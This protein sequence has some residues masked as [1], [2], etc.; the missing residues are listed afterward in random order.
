MLE[1]NII[2]KV[3]RIKKLNTS[4]CTRSSLN[5]LNSRVDNFVVKV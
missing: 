1:E 2:K 5:W 4:L 3:Q